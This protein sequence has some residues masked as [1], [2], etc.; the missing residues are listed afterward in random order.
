MVAF[1]LKYEERFQMKTFNNAN[2][3]VLTSANTAHSVATT[4]VDP[5][6]SSP[7]KYDLV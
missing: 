7:L 2:A 1:T 6:W 4:P 5:D 3:G